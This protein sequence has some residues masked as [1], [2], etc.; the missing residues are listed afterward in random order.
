MQGS[1]SILQPPTM[2]GIVSLFAASVAKNPAQEFGH[3]P[4]G[5]GRPACNFFQLSFNPGGFI[6]EPRL[7]AEIVQVSVTCHRIKPGA[8]IE[9]AQVHGQR[10]IGWESS[11]GRVFEPFITH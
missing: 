4:G 8:F 2:R 9:L 11:S 5:L 10:C 1:D 7:V 6:V 3:W